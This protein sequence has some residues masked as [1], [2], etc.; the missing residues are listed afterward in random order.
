MVSSTSAFL[1]NGGVTVF[2]KKLIHESFHTI[3]TMLDIFL[4]KSCIPINWTMWPARWTVWEEGLTH[5]YQGDLRVHEGSYLHQVLVDPLGECLLLHS[6]PFICEETRRRHWLSA[7]RRHVPQPCPHP[8]SPEQWRG[9]PQ[10]ETAPCCWE[11]SVSL[12]FLF[13]HFTH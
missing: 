4:R 8:A 10:P 11:G 2:T 9:F 5:S 3:R 12:D 6:V 1:G 13:C 7:T